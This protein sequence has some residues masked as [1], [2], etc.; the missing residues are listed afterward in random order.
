MGKDHE[1]RICTY[2]EAEAAIRSHEVVYVNGCFC[3]KPAQDG[4]TKWKYCGHPIETCMGFDKSA[5]EE[6]GADYKELTREK[7]LEMFDLWKKQGNLFR[8]MEDEKWICFC[9]TC[10]CQW[11]RDK[12]GNKTEDTCDPSPFIES[13]DLQK[14]N[15][16]GKCIGVCPKDL[17]VIKDKTL[18][19]DTTKCYGCSVCEYICPEDAVN[20]VPRLT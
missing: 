5:S 2:K 1:H 17:R 19:V 12:E 8:F 14:C 3:R 11:F 20:M 10:G 15:L 9:C 7:V 16:C 18:K 6:F 4:K 13:T